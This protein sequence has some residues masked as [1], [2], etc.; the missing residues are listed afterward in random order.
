M[1]GRSHP[2]RIFY[3]DRLNSGFCLNWNI[4]TFYTQLSLSFPRSLSSSNCWTDFRD[5]LLQWNEKDPPLC[6]EIRPVSVYLRDVVFLYW[7]ISSIIFCG[8]RCAMFASVFQLLFS[9]VIS[10][11]R[12]VLTPAAAATELVMWIRQQSCS[13]FCRLL[14]HVK[15]QHLTSSCLRWKQLHNTTNALQKINANKQ[16]KHDDM[17]DSE[18]PNKPTHGR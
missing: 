11:T 17:S 16:W 7:V 13:G 14:I 10:Q 1:S 12:S 18:S 4:T 3:S 9:T 2:R 6:T 15:Y 8:F 5:L